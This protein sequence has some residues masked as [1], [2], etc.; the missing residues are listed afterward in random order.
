MKR[1]VEIAFFSDD[2]ERMAAHYERLL[3]AEPVARSEG[4]AIFMVEGIK[5]FI[6]RK[7]EPGPGDL[8]PENHIAFAVQDVDVVCQDLL[9]SGLTFETLPQD[10]YWG[11]S[12]YLRDPDGHLVEITH[13][14]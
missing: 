12:A 10:Y 7:Y 5:I 1:L 2:V 4:M 3:G 13:D 11:R 9:Q 14:D 6:H 8:P